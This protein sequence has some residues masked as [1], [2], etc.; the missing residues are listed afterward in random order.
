MEFAWEKN[1][2]AF[3][4]IYEKIIKTELFIEGIINSI[5]LI[6]VDH[7]IKFS[8]HIKKDQR[9][10]FYYLQVNHMHLPYLIT[11]INLKIKLDLLLRE[12]QIHLRV[13]YLFL[14]IRWNSNLQSW[15]WRFLLYTRIIYTPQTVFFILVGIT[16]YFWHYIRSVIALKPEELYEAAP[17]SASYT[18]SQTHNHHSSEDD[19]HW[20][21]FRSKKELNC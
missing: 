5:K 2:L 17:L 16:F 7:T 18:D 12:L 21:C 19:A 8:C 3:S 15:N 11:R 9:M 6:V 1:N 4:L 14:L 20:G 10:A 13:F